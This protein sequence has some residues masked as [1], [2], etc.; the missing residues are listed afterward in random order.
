MVQ[1]YELLVNLLSLEMYDTDVIL[2]MKWLSKYDAIIDYF[3]KTVIFKKLGDL[4]F[5]FQGERKEWSP[6]IILIRI[7]KR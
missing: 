1:E 3:S 5:S 4:K 6:C 2:G 7:T